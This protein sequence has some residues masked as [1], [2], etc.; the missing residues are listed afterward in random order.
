M[1][2]KLLKHEAIY[3]LR[4]VL[5][6][7]AMLLLLA[8]F[9]RLIQFA[10]NDSWVY[11]LMFGSSIVVFIGACFA[12]YILV[13]ALSVIRFYKNLF[14]AEGYLSFTLPV[15]ETQHITSKLIAALAATLSVV[16]CM[17][18][19][20]VI[21]LSGEM[22]YELWK[23][24]AYLLKLAE[25]YIGAHLYFYILEYIVLI[26][27]GAVLGCLIYYSCIAIGQLFKKNR[28][29]AAV[30]VYFAYNVIMQFLS[31][32][33][34]IVYSI[35]SVAIMENEQVQKFIN[36]NLKTLIHSGMIGGILIYALMAVVLFLLIRFIMR[37]KLNLE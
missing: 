10:E 26:A 18:L 13:M 25:G 23:A 36:E 28:I 29:F 9:S 21:M 5:P 27:V 20:A 1:V 7:N 16:I 3:Y 22:L 8:V 2:K 33:F 19:G 34:S 35:A 32:A 37:R 24:A 17:I 4:W 6:V 14:T 11:S 30:G 12:G 15:S 31:T